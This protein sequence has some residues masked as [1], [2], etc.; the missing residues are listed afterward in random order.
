[1]WMIKNMKGYFSEE[2][3][4]KYATLVSEQSGI[5]Y[6]EGQVYDFR[7]CVMPS[8]EVYG[9]KG[10]CKVGK[11][12]ADAQVAKAGKKGEKVDTD[13][14]MSKLK[15]KFM[16]KIGRQMSPREIAQA[17]N[18]LGWPIPKGQ[19]AEDVLKKLLP[20]GSNVGVPVKTA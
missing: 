10:Q 5:N 12:I 1:M 16:E 4:S 19:T 3:L 2:T 7:R 9:T 14:M 17:S 13:S 6:S 18:M 20:K 8:G 11:Q 15:R